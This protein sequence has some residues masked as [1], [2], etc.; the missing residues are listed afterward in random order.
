MEPY[1]PSAGRQERPPT[2]YPFTPGTIG[3]WLRRGESLGR[4]AQ[5]A[6]MTIA[7]WRRQTVERLPTD[8]PAQPG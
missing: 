8:P 7:T 2:P 4:A 1:S 5:R 3:L 6:A